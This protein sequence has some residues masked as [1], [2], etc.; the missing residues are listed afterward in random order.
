MGGKEIMVQ[1]IDP[2]N[3]FKIEDYLITTSTGDFSMSIYNPM[4][5]KLRFS[6]QYRS[7]TIKIKNR[8][9]RK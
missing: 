1:V 2:S 3:P 8:R 5:D 7:N 9:N 6:L 4:I